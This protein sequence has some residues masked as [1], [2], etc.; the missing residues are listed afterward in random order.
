MLAD[1]KDMIE[2]KRDSKRNIVSSNRKIGDDPELYNNF[3][4]WKKSIRINPVV[5][6]VNRF[7]KWTDF[8]L[9]P[10]IRSNLEMHML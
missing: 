2:V 6:K 5:Y 4:E 8:V 10:I 7:L 1:A 3:E 9:D